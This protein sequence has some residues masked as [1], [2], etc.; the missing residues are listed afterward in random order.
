MPCIK[1]SGLQ[2]QS[3]ELKPSSVSESDS[4]DL[5]DSIDSEAE[6]IFGKVE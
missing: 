6:R 5:V 2:N 1:L 4:S 3:N